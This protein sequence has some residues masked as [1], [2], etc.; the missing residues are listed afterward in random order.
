MEG[1]KSYEWECSYKSSGVNSN[2]EPVDILHDFYI[3]ALKRIIKYDRVAGYFRSSSLAAASQGYTAF[4]NHGGTMRLV[5]GADLQ[6]E[7]V[8]AILQGNQQRLSDKLMEQLEDEQT[9]PAEVKNGVSLL[10]EMVSSGRLEVRVAF[11]INAETNEPIQADSVEDGYVHEKWF[12]M[13]DEAGDRI[14][15]SGS[16]NESRTALVVNA[17]NVS[18]SCDWEGGRE[19]KRV[20]QAVQDFEAL[21]T[22]QNPHMHVYKL[23]EAVQKKLVKLKT[24]R[25]RPTEIDGTVLRIEPKFS[26]LDILR[27]SVLQDAPKMPGGIYIGMYSAP[28]EPW[29]HQEVVSRRLIESFP[30]S[31]MLCDEV[32]LGKTIE[33]ALAIRSLILAGRAKRVLIV[34]PAGLSDQWHR[35]L[36]SKAMLPFAKS[37]SKPGVKG[38][39]LSKT[40]YP[41]EKELT[42]ANL[43]APAFNIVSQGLLYRKE[44]LSQLRASGQFDIVLVDEAHYA[45]RSNPRKNSTGAPKYG[46]LYRALQNTVRSRTNSMWLATATPMQI[47]AIE[48]YDL[49]KLTR[50]VG[51][52]MYDPTLCLEYFHLMSKMLSGVKLTIQEWQLLG[53]SFEQI[54]ALDNYLWNKVDKTVVNSKNRKVLQNLIIKEP[55]KPDIKYLKKPLFATSPLSRIMMRH[56]RALLEIYRENGEL[57]S[58]LARRHVLPIAAVQ[59]TEQE[60]IFYN[61]LKEYCDEL[62]EQIIEHNEQSKQVMTFLLNFLQLRFASSLDAIKLSLERRLE[63]V[64]KTLLVG[65]SDFENKEE[66][67]ARLEELMEEMDPGYEEDDLSDITLDSLLK[68]RSEQDLKW[69]QLK[70]TAMLHQLENVND[71]PSKIQRLLQVIN[72]R[73]TGNRVR[74]M[75]IFTRFLDTLNS[76]RKHLQFREKRLRVGVYAGGFAKTYSPEKGKDITVTHEEV[77]RL[78]KMGEIDIL[79]CT[80]AAAEGLNLQTADLLVN[81]DMGWNPM[82]IEQRIGRI[83]R[84]GQKH[85]DIDV[86]NMCYVGSTEEKV[87]GRLLERLA[88]AN[89]VVGMQQ[90]SMLPVTP[91]DFRDLE[92]GSL[93]EAELEKAAKEKIKAQQERIRS[94]EMGA[95]DLYDMY[96]QLSGE[97]RSQKLPAKVSDIMTAVRESDYFK[98][99]GLRLDDNDCLHIL[100]TNVSDGEYVITEDRNKVSESVHYLTWGNELMTD[101]FHEAAVKAEE[102]KWLKRIT[103]IDEGI[104]FCGYVVATKN[105]V[106]LITSY[107]QLTGV[108]PDEGHILTEEEITQFKEL[109]KNAAKTEFVRQKLVN[110]AAKY[111][112]VFALLHYNLIRRAAEYILKDMQQH[113]ETHIIDVLHILED[114]K[115][116]YHV[117][118]PFAEFGDKKR[119]LLFAIAVRNKTVHLVVQG[120]LIQL[121][122]E[123]LYREVDA[124]DGKKHEI[125]IDAVLRRL[126]SLRAS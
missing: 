26:S 29:P 39:A 69:E 8:A 49:L 79:L 66:L 54:K 119:S 14:A 67:A 59:F 90:I 84:I 19:A 100:Q 71:T 70:L 50:R 21:W 27:F 48:S 116:I 111:N 103:V 23:P 88:Q 85:N 22:N 16:L 35:E 126:V 114:E 94:M 9:W 17:E 115:K 104:S 123:M 1:L 20:K 122:R 92:N 120:L 99:C 106:K 110:A 34:P 24:L 33:A 87:Y 46:K 58:N 40:I 18:V 25:N 64:K 7:D 117:E 52:Y 76:I 28:I 43:F 73:R 55:K 30:Y 61:S 51:P 96:K 105:G 91:Q 5:V 83:D 31:Y 121:I 63:K 42:N 53:Q 81:F 41:Q 74:Q 93:T 86:L 56:T 4:L 60:K 65:Q 77:K 75:V 125:T 97:A 37:T 98:A 68:Q 3:P 57:K 107:G 89:L 38:Y 62:K 10:A 101:V 95:D 109:L 13:E 36:A 102:T 82:K 113:G 47:D 11:R 45:R 112:K 118:L 12:V 6:I 124:M 108:E 15:G 72:E 44:R 80:D 2:G 78:F 32:G